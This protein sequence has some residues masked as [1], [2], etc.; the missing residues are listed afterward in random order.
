[1]ATA[2][3]YARSEERSS[4]LKNPMR[5]LRILLNGMCTLR[6]IKKEVPRGSADIIIA[7]PDT[8]FGGSGAP[9]RMRKPKNITRQAGG[10]CSFCQSYSLSPGLPFALHALLQTTL[11]GWARRGLYGLARRSQIN[12]SR[13]TCHA[14][15]LFAWQRKSG[16]HGIRR[17][18]AVFLRIEPRLS[19]RA[20]RK[21]WA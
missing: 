5:L 17:K 8:C 10:I 12:F 15:L 20:E 2:C 21:R 4:I 6:S 3:R 18:C 9:H 11:S 1:M 14:R 16:I 19:E 7:F 13:M